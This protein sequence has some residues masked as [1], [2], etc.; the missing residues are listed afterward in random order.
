[1]ELG[2]KLKQ[3]REK[4]GYSQNDIAEKLNISRQSVSRWET[5]RTYPDIENLVLLGEIYGVSLDFLLKDSSTESSKEIPVEAKDDY[6]TNEKNYESFFIIAT[7]LISCT[8]PIVGLILNTGLIFFSIIRKKKLSFFFWLILVMC[9]VVNLTNTFII[10]NNTF[11]DIGKATIEK[12][13][14]NNSILQMFL[15]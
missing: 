7:A 1:M 2:I 5:G 12:V 14:F 13:A 10:L 6:L 9:L 3:A 11:F 15:V 8:V 4:S